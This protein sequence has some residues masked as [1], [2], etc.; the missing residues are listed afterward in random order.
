MW[1]VLRID[2]QYYHLDATWNDNNNDNKKLT[3]SYFNIN[4][5]L[6]QKTHIVEERFLGVCKSMDD[7][8]YIKSNLYFNAYDDSFKNILSKR[9]AENANENINRISFMFSNKDAYKK[10][11]DKLINKQEIYRI[12]DMANMQTDKTINTM[13][14][15]YSLDEKH[16]IIVLSEYIK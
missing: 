15:V 14:I 9:I 2:G 11:S 13:K 6:I 8:Y 12:L 4:D 10:A 1:N 7:N 16:N 3:Y 5:E